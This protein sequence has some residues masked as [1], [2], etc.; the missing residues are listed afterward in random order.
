MLSRLKNKINKGYLNKGK[1]L[2][3]ILNDST[4]PYHNASITVIHYFQYDYIGHCNLRS[5]I[6][7]P[8][9]DPTQSYKTIFF[10][11]LNSYLQAG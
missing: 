6:L 10:L 8:N 9:S 1:I 5:K 4:Q 3:A 2:A 7:E 11:A